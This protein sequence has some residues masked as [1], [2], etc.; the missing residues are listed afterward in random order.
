MPKSIYFRAF[1][2][3][4]CGEIPS[5]CGY[6]Q[7]GEL[8]SR[9][10]PL[11]YKIYFNTNSMLFLSFQL[12]ASCAWLV[13]AARLFLFKFQCLFEQ[14]L[15]N[16]LFHIVRQIKIWTINIFFADLYRQAIF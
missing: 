9:T 16:F 13:A 5:L 15:F 3:F 1:C 2:A 6:K 10:A 14:R 12:C 8:S 11:A 7:K 4:R